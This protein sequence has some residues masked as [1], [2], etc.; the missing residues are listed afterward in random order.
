[1]TAAAIGHGAKFS[2]A[3]TIAS[4]AGAYVDLAEVYDIKPPNEQTDTVDATHYGSPGRNR[5]FIQGL[6]DPGDCSFEM[7]LVPGSTSEGLII[8][9]RADGVLR[10]CKITLPGGQTWNFGGLVT[11]YEA[12]L[13]ND[14]KMTAT[15]TMKV[16][17]SVTRAAAA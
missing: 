2:I 12:A 7:N 6:T 4:A 13:P 11:G 16:S 14:G 9:A 1:M 17:G 8:A 3:P 15:T 5:E 10:G